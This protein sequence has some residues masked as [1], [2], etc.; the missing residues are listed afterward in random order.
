MRYH[1]GL[2]VGHL[3]AH[4]T[5]AAPSNKPEMPP[6]QAGDMQADQSPDCIPADSE[7]LSE[8]RV[9][10]QLPPGDGDDHNSIYDS[11]CPELGLDDRQ[12]EGWEDVDS[13][14]ELELDDAEFEGIFEDE[15]M[16]DEDEDFTGL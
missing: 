2:G 8:S 10:A 9:D 4:Q 15:D 6:S 12:A 14:N 3:H 5:S 7:V 16:D 11:D 13:D 1:W